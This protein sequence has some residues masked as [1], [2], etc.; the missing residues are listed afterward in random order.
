MTDQMENIPALRFPE[1][2]GEWEN[3]KLGNI[4]DFKGGGTPSKAVSEYWVGDIPWVSSSD[5]KEGDIHN[6]DISRFINEKSIKESATK[7]IPKGSI[8]FVSRVGVGKLAVNK[9]EVCTSQDFTSLLSKT[10][11]SYFLGYFFLARNNLLIRFSQGTSIKGFT[12]SDIES[13]K[14]HL[15]S[16]PEQQKIADFLTTVDEKIQQLSKKYR[17]LSQYKKGVIE[18][19]F[20]QQIRFKDDKGQSY[21][22]WE[23]KRLGEFLSFKTTNSLSRDALKYDSG[24]VQ[25]IHYGDIHTQFKSNFYLNEE[26]VPYV[27]NDI[28]LSKISDDCYCQTGDLI[29]ADASEDYKDIGKAIEIID[30]KDKK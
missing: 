30:T 2:E 12:K 15:P 27:K 28:N 22:A 26:R 13:L 21:P 6:I 23:E 14:L 10:T 24:D 29:V 25:N 19:I 11:N 16:V 5:I 3:E 9:K 1:F 4:G 8:L 18:Q 20:S 7:V 17:L